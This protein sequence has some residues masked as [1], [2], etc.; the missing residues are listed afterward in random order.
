L[1]TGDAPEVHGVVAATEAPRLLAWRMRF[2]DIGA[3]AFS[4]G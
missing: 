2:G 1:A 3:G 4:I